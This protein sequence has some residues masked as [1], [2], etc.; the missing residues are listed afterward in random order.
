MERCLEGGD[1]K[2]L[3]GRVE[4]FSQHPDALPLLFYRGRYVVPGPGGL[5]SPAPDLAAESQ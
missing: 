4:R 2:I 3:I 5:F 1:H